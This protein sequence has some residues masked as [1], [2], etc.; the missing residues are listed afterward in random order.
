MI[1][2]RR[3]PTSRSPRNLGTL[4]SSTF[5]TSKAAKHCRW[6]LNRLRSKRRRKVIDVTARRFDLSRGSQLLERA[7]L[8]HWGEESYGSATVGYLDRLSTTDLTEQLARPL[9]Q[10]P[11]SHA[12]HVLLIAHRVSHGNR[13][14]GNRGHTLVTD[15]PDE[16]EWAVSAGMGASASSLLLPYV[17]QR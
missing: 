1:Q 4:Q 12:N 17:A 7:P 2:A 14:Q 3:S 16:C 5:L 11:N 6:Q 8:R 15:S 9:S 13:P 10:L